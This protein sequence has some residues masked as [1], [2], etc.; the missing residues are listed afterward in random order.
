M[1]FYLSIIKVN[2][3]SLC[4]YIK[5]DV[6]D[7]SNDECFLYCIVGSSN[8]NNNNCLDKCYNNYDYSKIQCYKELPS[9]YFVNEGTNNKIISK[10]SANCKTCDS[11]NKNNICL[12]CNTLSNYKPIMNST[13]NK[14]YSCTNRLPEGFYLESNSY[15]PCYPTCKTCNTNG[16]EIDNKCIQ[17]IPNK[18]F[19][20]NNCLEHCNGY[21]FF[22]SNL[23][24]YQCVE[25]CPKGYIYSKGK[26]C[27]A[28]CDTNP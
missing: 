24:A 27:K 18:D 20:E 23:H 9:G 19:V 5:S 6:Y 3:Y 1:Y 4:L 11:Q 16:N 22:N 8:G 15:K 21:Y 17:C 13:D 2:N 26:I 14:H 10:C 12:E 7:F 25:K 28:D